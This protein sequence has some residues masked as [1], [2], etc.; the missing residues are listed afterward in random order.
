MQEICQKNLHLVISLLSLLLFFVVY[1]IEYHCLHCLQSCL[2][3]LPLSFAVGGV[4][5]PHG[6][7]VDICC[8][9]CCKQNSVCCLDSLD[10]LSPFGRT[11][12]SWRSRHRMLLFVVLLSPLPW[13]NVGATVII[14]R[15]NAR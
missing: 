9:C 2:S 8:Y 4:L 6:I 5:F 7:V 11:I 15:A 12:V 14:V 10:F 1:V 3:C 13:H